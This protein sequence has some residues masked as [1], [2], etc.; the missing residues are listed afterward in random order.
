MKTKRQSIQN[1]IT[2]NDYRTFKTLIHNTMFEEKVTDTNF[3]K[4]VQ[5]QTHRVAGD[6]KRCKI[7]MKELNLKTNNYKK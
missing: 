2:S 1:V 4:L 3:T 7:L 5:A 6:I